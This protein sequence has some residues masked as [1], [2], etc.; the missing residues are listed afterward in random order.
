MPKAFL[1]IA[2]PTVNAPL[3]QIQRAHRAGGRVRHV[4]PYAHPA[5]SRRDGRLFDPNRWPTV[6]P[7]V[8]LISVANVPAQ[9]EIVELLKYPLIWPGVTP[10]SAP[11]AFLE[12]VAEV[13]ALVEKRLCAALGFDVANLRLRVRRAKHVQP[14]EDK[15]RH[16][17]AQGGG[18][19]VWS[20]GWARRSRRMRPP[21]RRRPRPSDG[22]HRTRGR[23]R[24]LAR[25]PRSCHSRGRTSRIQRLCEKVGRDGEPGVTS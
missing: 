6:S 21:P 24:P 13:V 16:F 7:A 15:V 20:R 3:R 8:V 17:S 4:D 5:A 18:R 11:D 22:T 25:R 9:L 23:Q 2:V 10:G 1:K 12:P 19:D 14:V